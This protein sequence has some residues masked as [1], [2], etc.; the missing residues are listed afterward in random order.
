MQFYKKTSQETFMLSY[1]KF[2]SVVQEEMS[3]KVYAR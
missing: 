3:F 1:L 2:G